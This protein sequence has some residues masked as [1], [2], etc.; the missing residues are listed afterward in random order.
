MRVVRNRANA[1]SPAEVLATLVQALGIDPELVLRTGGSPARSSGPE[2]AAPVS[3]VLRAWWAWL[4]ALL[5]A[6]AASGDPI[7]P[8]TA[9]ARWGPPFECSQA[10]VFEAGLLGRGCWP[11][12]FSG[13]SRSQVAPPVQRA[14]AR[15]VGAH[16]GAEWELALLISTT[17]SARGAASPTTSSTR[18]RCAGR[19]PGGR[20]VPDGV[21]VS[22]SA[23]PRRAAS[24]LAPRGAR[25]RRAFS[26]DGI[27][28]ASGGH[29][30]V[31]LLGKPGAQSTG[32][33]RPH[34]RG[35]L[36]A[37]DSDGR[38]LRARAMARCA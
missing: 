2:D 24:E 3:E 31:I 17:A 20:S 34:G 10:G 36:P 27:L 21:V 14:A 25:G 4:P 9:T 23:R 19:R 12:L 1:R 8:V 18:W 38:P 29:D 11:A 26:P 22:A 16:P 32:A 28:L 15:L 5:A 7:G 13:R 6:C 35:H 30:G 33:A 37:V